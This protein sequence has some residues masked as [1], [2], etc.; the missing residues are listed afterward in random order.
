MLKLK[1]CKY[2]KLLLYTSKYLIIAI[3][4][5]TQG[6]LYKTEAVGEWQYSSSQT[7]QKMTTGA[8]FDLRMPQHAEQSC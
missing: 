2:F 4:S 3:N 8:K 1:H 7:S 6:L 5:P